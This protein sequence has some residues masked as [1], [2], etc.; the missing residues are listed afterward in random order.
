MK[1]IEALQGDF[2]DETIKSKKEKL[3]KEI[4]RLE[5]RFIEDALKSDGHEDTA[6]ETVKQLQK[7]RSKP[8]FLWKRIS[9]MFL[10]KKAV[11]I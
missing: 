8:F 1:G 11:S 6:A 2:F 3:R 10:L 5:W 9:V 4:D 7:S